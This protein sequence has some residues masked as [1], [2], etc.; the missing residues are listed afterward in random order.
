MASGGSRDHGGPALTKDEIF[1]F[2]RRLAERD[3]EH[4][5]RGFAPDTGQRFE[6]L[7]VARHLG[8]MLRDKPA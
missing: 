3:V 5:V 8:A 6:R 1:E 2:F 7:A 4:D